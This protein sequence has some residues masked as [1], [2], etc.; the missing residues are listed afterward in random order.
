MW[1]I[2]KATGIEISNAQFKCHRSQ[3]N[4]IEGLEK[5]YPVKFSNKSQYSIAVTAQTKKPA[6]NKSQVKLLAVLWFICLKQNTFS[7]TYTLQF[8]RLVLRYC[9]CH[10]T[11][12]PHIAGK[13]G[14]FMAFHCK[15]MCNKSLIGSRLTL[16]E[17]M[18]K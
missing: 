11:F 9:Q 2:D 17:R 10:L 16:N 18:A 4:W 14:S 7:F 5:M 6:P 13:T 15:H 1:R 8:F 12:P 3:Q